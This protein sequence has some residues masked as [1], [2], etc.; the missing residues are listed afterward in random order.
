M[1]RTGLTSITEAAKALGLSRQRVWVLV[2][3]GRLKAE[4]V[5]STWVIDDRSLSNYLRERK[6]K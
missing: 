2:R 4:K 6:E 5:G 3:E 1:R